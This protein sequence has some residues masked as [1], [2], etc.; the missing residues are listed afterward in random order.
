[1]PKDHTTWMGC[2]VDTHPVNIACKFYMKYEYWPAQIIY[3][4]DA[5]VD[6]TK[7]D[8]Q[9]LREWGVRIRYDERAKTVALAG[10]IHHVE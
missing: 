10:P 5:Q 2:I 3:P 8:T 9:K 1:M 7:A 4:K 6:Y